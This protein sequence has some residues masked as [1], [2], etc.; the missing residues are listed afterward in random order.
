V[1]SHIT[2]RRSSRK[3]ERLPGWKM[4][5]ENML[6][7]L[8]FNGCSMAVQWLFNDKKRKKPPRT[9]ENTFAVRDVTL[10]GP[11]TVILNCR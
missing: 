4:H 7:M 2:K 5:A 8:L 9:F 10:V 6:Q 1:T 3:E 11:S